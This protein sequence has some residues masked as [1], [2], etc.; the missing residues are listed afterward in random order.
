MM[1]TAGRLD[2]RIT[3]QARGA[4]TD[5]RLGTRKAGGWGD[6][7]TVW[8]EVQDVLPSRAERLDE[9]INIARRPARIRIRYRRDITSD[10]RIVYGERILQIVAGPVEIGRRDG[11]EL[12]AEEFSSGRETA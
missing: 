12:M 9:S 10:M 2:R 6:H 7:V 8:A 1:L 4:A 5:A 3:F 11:L